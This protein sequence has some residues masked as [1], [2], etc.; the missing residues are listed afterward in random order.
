VSSD[1]PCWV[2]PSTNTPNVGGGRMLDVYAYVLRLGGC[3]IRIQMEVSSFASTAR[4]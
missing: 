3:K 2:W 4:R 1:G